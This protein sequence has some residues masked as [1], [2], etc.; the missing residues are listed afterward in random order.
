MPEIREAE[1]P[2]RLEYYLDGERVVY[3]NTMII[4][5]AGTITDVNG[6][7]HRWE[8]EFLKPHYFQNRGAMLHIMEVNNIIVSFLVRS[9]AYYMDNRINFGYGLTLEDL[10]N[11]EPWHFHINFN[12]NEEMNF[13]TLTNNRFSNI[14]EAFNEL[15]NHLDI[16]LISW[17]GPLQIKN[18]FN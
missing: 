3:S 12:S 4:R 11:N 6:R 7:F 2:I 13:S 8:R 10:D 17:K 18:S 1:F 15:S 14:E 9:S 5:F 16:E